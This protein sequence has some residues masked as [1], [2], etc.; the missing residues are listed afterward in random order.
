MK[1]IIENLT[2]FFYFTSM[3]VQ[4]FIH[5]HIIQIQQHDYPNFLVTKTHQNAK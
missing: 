2:L 1:K 3:N 5:F 4:T